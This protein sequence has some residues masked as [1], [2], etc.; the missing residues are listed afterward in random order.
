MPAAER[1]D[2]SLL[3]V[4]DLHHTELVGDRREFHFEWDGTKAQSN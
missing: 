1:V 2:R 3:S 4:H